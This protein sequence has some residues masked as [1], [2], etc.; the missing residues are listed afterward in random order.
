MGRVSGWC[1]D[2]RG[3]RAN[4]LD[5]PSDRC[6]IQNL[7]LRPVCPVRLTQRKRNKSFADAHTTHGILPPDPY[8][9]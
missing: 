2:A 3:R 4:L 7:S 6:R 8:A 1:Q 5:V 9:Y